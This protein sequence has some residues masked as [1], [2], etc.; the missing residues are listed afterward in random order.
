MSELRDELEEKDEMID[1]M[2]S[3]IKRLTKNQ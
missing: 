3:T 2:K 1:Q